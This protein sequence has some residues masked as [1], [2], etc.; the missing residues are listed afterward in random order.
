MAATQLS[1][2]LSEEESNQN[3][4]VMRFS[5]AEEDAQVC[6]GNCLFPV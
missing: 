2:P 3:R 4:N 6:N 5:R 1:T